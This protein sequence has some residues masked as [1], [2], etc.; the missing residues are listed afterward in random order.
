MFY[1]HLRPTDSVVD[2]LR[3]WQRIEEYSR[4]T[5]LYTGSTSTLVS[6]EHQGVFHN[7]LSAA[8]IST[9]LLSGIGS[10]SLESLLHLRCLSCRVLY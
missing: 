1:S 3:C 9:L 8:Y 2:S 4:Q 10:N 5:T 7:P 6:E